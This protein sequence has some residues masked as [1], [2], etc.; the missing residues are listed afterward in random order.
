M[1]CRYWRGWTTTQGAPPYERLLRHTIIP[2]IESRSIPGFRGI[3]LMRRPLENE[4]EF[5]T[6]MWF[7]DLAAVVSFVGDDLE[8]AHVPLAARTLLSRFDERVAHYKVLDRRE[9]PSLTKP[10][11]S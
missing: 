7:D 6:I 8:A 9:Q 1:I 4:V 11:V 2:G 10:K 5:A 3:D